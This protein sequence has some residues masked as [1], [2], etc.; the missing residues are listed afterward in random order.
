LASMLNILEEQGEL[1]NTLIVVTSANGMPFPR[2][3]TTLYDWGTR[4]PLTI[5]W[6]NKIKGGRDVD[7]RVAHTDFAPT[8]LEAAGLDIPTEM[9]G[10]S[11]LPI[12]MS[13]KEGEVEKER[14]HIFTATERHTWCRPEGATYPARAIRSKEYLYIR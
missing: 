1:D 5:R 10:K 2:A 14:D 6:G 12:L 4:M 11:L 7:D 9:T 8:F 3:K 13:E